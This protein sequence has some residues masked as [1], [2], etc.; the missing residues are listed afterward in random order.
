MITRQIPL[1]VARILNDV[2]DLGQPHAGYTPIDLQHDADL[3]D[4][5][6][7]R[8]LIVQRTDDGTHWAL[9]LLDDEL[10]PRFIDQARQT[11]TAH[12]VMAVRTIEYVMVRPKK[13]PS[14]A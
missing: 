4:G 7:E 5:H 12:Q 9:P 13:A 11:L 1:D 6:E 8:F 10:N 3:P 14:Y 2:N